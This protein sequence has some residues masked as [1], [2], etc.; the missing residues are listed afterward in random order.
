MLSDPRIG[1]GISLGIAVAAAT[2]LIGQ[3]VAS[4]LLWPMLGFT[5]HALTL[6]AIFLLLTSILAACVFREYALVR[7]DLLADR[8]VLAR[9]RMD[10]AVF[11]AFGKAQAARELGER[12]TALHILL[13]FV[14]VIFGGFALLDFAAARSMIASGALVA[15]TITAAFFAGNR[16]TRK[17][18]TMRSGEVIVGKRGVLVNGVLHVWGTFLSRL[19]GATLER[20]S[21]PALRISYSVLARHAR[22]EVAVTLPLAPHQIDMARN[23]VRQLRG[24]A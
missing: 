3:L 15:L 21:N 24:D 9:W 6:L 18:L 14:A 11:R 13:I 23:V 1:F 20:G 4:D 8:N 12:R 22:Q 10:E 19:S 5:T 17:Q 2:W 16:V 7:A